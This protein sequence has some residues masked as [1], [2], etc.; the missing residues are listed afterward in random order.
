MLLPIPPN[1]AVLILLIALLS[2][3]AQATTVIVITSDQGISMATDSQE[4][5][6][7]GLATGRKQVTK[8]LIIQDRIAIASLGWGNFELASARQVATKYDFGTWIGIIE[9]RLPPKVPVDDFV[10][11]IKDEVS[12]MVPQWQ[13]LISSGAMQH[14]NPDQIFES[15]VEYVIAGY[16]DGMPRLSVIQLY[17][18]WDTK[19]IFGPYQVPFELLAGRLNLQLFGI[20][21][22]AAN[23]SNSQSYAYKKTMARCPEAF[24]DLIAHGGVTL[25]KTNTLARVLVEIEEETSPNDV[26]G[27][28]RIIEISPTGGAHVVASTKSLPKAKTGGERKKDN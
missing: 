11:I 20:A 6:V 17:V 22:A 12:K 26:G 23:V 19:L 14:K 24:Q 7:A 16:R 4:A 9:S 13:L 3:Q 2:T 27:Q 25:D 28:T 8:S 5:S 21:Q 15:L 18:N 10:G 1:K